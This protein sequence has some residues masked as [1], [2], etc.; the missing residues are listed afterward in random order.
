MRA[1]RFS[2]IRFLGVIAVIL[3]ISWSW[4]SNSAQAGRHAPET[5][6][7]QIETIDTTGDVGQYTSL[8][9]KPGTE[10]PYISYYDNTQGDLKLAF[11]V[12][13]GGDCGPANTWSCNSLYFPNTADFGTFTSLDF[14]SLGHWGI[15]YGNLLS[16][17][18]EF[19]GSPAVGQELFFEP[20]EDGPNSV[21]VIS[22]SMQYAPNDVSYL[23]YGLIDVSQT[24]GFV[25]LAHYVGFG[26][27][28]CGGTFWQCEQIVQ[29]SYDYF[30]IYTSLAL[31]GIPYIFYRDINNHLS[32]AFPGFGNCGPSNTWI[33]TDLDHT[34]DVNG[35]IS[36]FATD[37]NLLGVA[38]IGDDSL[39]FASQDSQGNC[40]SDPIYFQCSIIDA[41]GPAPNNAYMAVSLGVYNGQPIIAYTDTNDRS[42]IAVLKIAYPQTDGNC[43]PLDTNLQHTWRCEV[44]DDGN[45]TNDVGYYPSLQV[46]SV[47]NIHI[48]YYD[49]SAK[50]LKY[51]V[52]D[53]PINPTPTPTSTPSITPTATPTAGA[54][55]HW[56]YLPLVIR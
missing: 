4:L 18:N 54:L 39:R 17:V 5:L 23:S 3:A 27:G 25:K 53:T 37:G 7:W 34:I 15:V 45:N 11:P 24:K 12:S 14:N 51:A 52:S 2:D 19:R 55:G 35:F 29:T 44:V 50:D 31:P 22:H 49:L 32:M 46:D 28:N 47:G 42:G 8:A 16:G 26:Q 13:G 36:S 1:N 56:V 40:G 41:V 33:C 21:F 48:S 9:L 20:I 6:T 10:D 30:V 38:Y 43:G